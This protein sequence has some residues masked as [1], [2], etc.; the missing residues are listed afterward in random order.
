M[1]IFATFLQC[2][3]SRRMRVLPSPVPLPTASMLAALSTGFCII[4]CLCGF[5]HT[6]TS[7]LCSGTCNITESCACAGARV[8]SPTP[9]PVPTVLVAPA[10]TEKPKLLGGLL[11]KKT[12]NTFPTPEPTPEETPAPNTPTLGELLKNKTPAAT[13]V[14]TVLVPIT[15]TVPAVAVSGKTLY[16][17]KLIPCRACSCSLKIRGGGGVGGGCVALE[18]MRQKCF[19][20]ASLLVS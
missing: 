8:A 18:L 1:L 13:P 10:D 2:S 14:E 17:T 9:V 4:R 6:Y 19:R 15:S 12:L 20:C 5:T 3:T 11:T 16:S 7:A